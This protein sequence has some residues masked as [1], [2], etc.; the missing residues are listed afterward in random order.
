MQIREN[1]PLASMTT[2]GIGGAARFFAHVESVNELTE[3][4]AFAQTEK[5]PI[6]ILGGGSNVL[7]SDSGFSGLVVKI[8][9][10]GISLKPADVKDP[11]SN[12]R[13]QRSDLTPA[14]AGSTIRLI[15]GAGEEWDA[16]VE[17]AVHEN[18]WGVENLSGIPGT[19][20]GA[21]AQ[22]IGAYGAAISEALQW[23]EAFDSAAGRTVRLNNAECRF[24]YRDSVFKHRP[25]LIVVRAAL[26]LSRK[27]RPNLSYRDVRERFGTAMPLLAEIRAAILK[28]RAGKFP[29]LAREGTA[30][31]FFKNP[32]LPWPEAEALRARYPEMPL[33]SMPETTLIK[34]PLAWLLDHAL[35]LKA[36]RIG[37][38]RLFERQPLVIV[39]DRG[40]RAADIT[41]LAEL[42]C[43][44][45]R[46]E[47]GFEIEEEV[48]KLA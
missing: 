12:P 20:G 39:A 25:E 3:A 21:I 48:K 31:S 46:E 11:T 38:A 26:V 29:D 4:F 19:L 13:P 6:F 14:A 42:V 22:N 27:P 5:V 37:G 47:F 32:V 34:V 45:V 2:F 10:R 9:L 1:V 41:A 17:R 30:G 18:L 33:F 35:H 24:G 28:I 43:S 7:I 36:V 44:R 16:I 23:A 8:E 40:A 15:A